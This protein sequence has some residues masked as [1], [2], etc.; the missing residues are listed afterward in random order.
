MNKVITTNVLYSHKYRINIEVDTGHVWKYKST[1][2][3]KRPTTLDKLNVKFF[4]AIRPFVKTTHKL[5]KLHTKNTHKL[6]HY[7]KLKHYIYKKGLLEFKS[8]FSVVNFNTH[9]IIVKAI[10][11]I[12]KRPPTRGLGLF[13]GVPRG[14]C[15]QESFKSNYGT[16]EGEKMLSK[17]E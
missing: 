4:K 14:K 12:N 3:E 15:K 16:S 13:P 9:L 7:T 11:R 8:T 2:N 6:K 1:K 17:A 5:H 10:E